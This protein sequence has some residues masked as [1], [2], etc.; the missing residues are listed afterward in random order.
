LEAGGEAQNAAAIR[1]PNKVMNLWRSEVDWCITS[2]PQPQLG[3]RTIDLDRGKTLG[4]TSCLNW[5][6]YV[7]GAPEDYD[8]WA[9]GDIDDGRVDMGPGLGD[10]WSHKG[11]LPNFN[12][13]ERVTAGAIGAGGD[14]DR[15]PEGRG[16]SGPMT[17]RVTS[18]TPEGEA[19]VQSFTKLRDFARSSAGGPAL[20]VLRNDDYNGP[21]TQAGVSF[22]QMNVGTGASRC[23]AFNSFVAPVL[24][25]KNLVVAS[26]AHVRRVVLR[27]RSAQGEERFEVTGVEVEIFKLDKAARKVPE[28][29]FV[30]LASEGEVVLSAGA[31]HSPTILMMSG[32]GDRDELKAAGVPAPGPTIESAQTADTEYHHVP[33]VGRHLQDHPALGFAFQVA[34]EHVPEVGS[35]RA[36]STGTSAV[37]FGKSEKD[38]ER[39]FDESRRYKGG[40]G[41]D[42]EFI[43]LARVD[44]AF[45]HRMFV[46][47]LSGKFPSIIN[48]FDSTYAQLAT[49]WRSW[50]LHRPLAYGA[51]RLALKLAPS[52]MERLVGCFSVLHHPL[53]R[54][55][56]RL[57]RVSSGFSW[58]AAPVVDVGW[59][60]DERDVETAVWALKQIRE[61]FFQEPYSS[62][63]QGAELAPMVGIHDDNGLPR[64]TYD[65]GAGAINDSR[66][67]G[68]FAM[69]AG[70]ARRVQASLWAA[71]RA[72]GDARLK[73][74]A[75]SSVATT[76]H[77]SCTARMGPTTS[78]IDDG[79]YV[80]DPKLRVR[81]VRGL[82]VADCSVMPT[83]VSANTNAAAMMIGDKCGE[84]ILGERGSTTLSRL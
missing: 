57:R 3:G 9:Q 22:T 63:T 55:S 1:I 42:I 2:A 5:C 47:M 49:T 41:P 25:R 56:L 13:L 78:P 70:G 84:I 45:F 59:L 71:F 32:I 79:L 14:P 36:E 37:C 15:V 51:D 16:D 24:H 60:R 44:P 7:Q 67:S 50:M 77:Y 48:G 39:D 11:V 82:R 58:H 38:R 66:P 17:P 19:F 75:L 40:T 23:D 46:G 12:N 81:G 83:V 31:I 61:L 29:V 34:P 8:R 33:A 28:V 65:D 80:C 30:P 26:G 6:M 53:S 74:Y 68:L 54:G 73:Q 21:V 18:V 4:G 69:G 76:W 62:Y 64:S 43:H 72:A 27:P 35:R 10:L 20:P 52:V